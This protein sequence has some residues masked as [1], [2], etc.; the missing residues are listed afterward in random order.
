[1]IL[2]CHTHL[3]SPHTL[4][5]PFFEGWGE[6]I[7]RLLPPDLPE[8]HRAKIAARYRLDRPD[9]NG[10]HHVAELNAAGIDVAVSLIVDF[11]FAFEGHVPP[12]ED[13]FALHHAMALRHPG[14]FWVFAG[15]DPRRGQAGVDL[16]ARS[17]NEWG[18]R[19]LK[20]YPPC[21]YSPSDRALDPYYDLCA[22]H[23]V[24]VLTH[25]GPTTP[26]LSFQHTHPADVEGAAHRFPTV[27]FIL[28]HGAVVHREDAA[29]L[30]EYR[31]NVYVDTAG[32]QVAI[33]RGEWNDALMRYKRQGI[34]RKLLF[35]S[36]W[37]IHAEHGPLS[38]WLPRLT[39]EPGLLTAAE[40]RWI[41]EDNHR[42]LWSVA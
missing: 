13:V 30:A 16:F 12:I 34:L 19:G 36:D 25:T 8:R 39:G 29:L 2:D 41:L 40:R 20:L 32:F 42:E 35:G 1:M 26:K 31:P 38:G 27:N 6:N 10:D 3:A 37:P 23:H 28:A 22:Q 24:P 7:R 9:P 33:K 15:I 14:R 5:E 11:G 17:L 21:G 4:P 18:V